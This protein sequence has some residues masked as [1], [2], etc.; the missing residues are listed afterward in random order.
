[1]DVLQRRSAKQMAKITL[2]EFVLYTKESSS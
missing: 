2:D 1:M